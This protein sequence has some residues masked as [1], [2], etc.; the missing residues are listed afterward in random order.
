[1]HKFNASI[2][3]RT[4]QN[5]KS[6]LGNSYNHLKNIAGHIDHG[7]HIAK[8]VYSVLEPV[9]RHATGNNHI[10]AHAMKAISGYENIRNKVSEANHHVANIGHKI[11]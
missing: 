6:H 11:G 1:M 9:I 4:L 3:H 7:V 5:V 10:H 2:F 8:Q